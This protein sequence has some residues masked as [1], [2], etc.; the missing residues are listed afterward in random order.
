M[1]DIIL[2]LLISYLVMNSICKDLTKLFGKTTSPTEIVAILTKYSYVALGI[3]WL[4]FSF[5]PYFIITLIFFES[6]GR[7]GT[8]S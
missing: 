7:E 2:I 3:G 8:A 5:K 4:V 1:L 6:F